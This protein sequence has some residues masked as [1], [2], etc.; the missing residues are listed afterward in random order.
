MFLNWRNCSSSYLTSEEGGD[1]TFTEILRSFPPT[2]MGDPSEFSCTVN[3]FADSLF[4]CYFLKL[5]I[6]L[7][8]IVVYFSEVLP[9]LM[10][11]EGSG[12]RLMYLRIIVYSSS[13]YF[14]SCNCLRY[15]FYRSII[16]CLGDKC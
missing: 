4:A 1:G 5:I 8:T 6:C 15:C 16:A 13:S 14:S 10:S 7:P 11:I 9:F 12:S 2:I 3:L